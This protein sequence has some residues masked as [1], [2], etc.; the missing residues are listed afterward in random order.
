MLK[1]IEFSAITALAVL[2]AVAF[3]LGVACF[4]LT[5]YHAENAIGSP[6]STSC[7][8]LIFVPIYGV[9]GAIGGGILGLILGFILRFFKI[10]NISLNK[11]IPLGFV[12]T[13][14]LLLIGGLTGF[15]MV[16]NY[17]EFN[18]P[19]VIYSGGSVT[20][21][22]INAKSIAPNNVRISFEQRDKGSL[23]VWNDTE[24]NLSF[25]SDE[26]RA[27]DSNGNIIIQT[28][29]SKFDY[30]GEL[31]SRE[32]RLSLSGKNYL[33]VLAHLRATSGHTMLLIYSPCGSLVYQEMFDAR[34]QGLIM[35]IDKLASGT[36]SLIVRSNDGTFS[37][38]LK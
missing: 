24:I 26:I 6:S 18:E 7:L 22:A 14:G 31:Q 3:G 23:I 38:S 9:V 19:R 32:V 20:K 33:A 5:I 37:Y 25:P 11:L 1:D 17:V 21:T 27:F 4:L 15:T 36:E 13:I 8:I 28:S 16:R 34:G 29:L 30:V 12:F 10:S 2:F 35:G